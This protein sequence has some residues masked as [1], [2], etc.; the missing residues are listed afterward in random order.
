MHP[1]SKAMMIAVLFSENDLHLKCDQPLM[2]DIIAEIA[3]FVT[4]CTYVNYTCGNLI[5]L[6]V[7]MYYSIQCFVF[8][9]VCH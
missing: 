8:F 7:L 2:M 4:G 6:K 1:L 5:N 3:V 9:A